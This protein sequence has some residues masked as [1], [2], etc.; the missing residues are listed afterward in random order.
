MAVTAANKEDEAYSD[1]NVAHNETK[2]KNAHSTT[3]ENDQ[4]TN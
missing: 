3:N 4:E 1:A 2:T